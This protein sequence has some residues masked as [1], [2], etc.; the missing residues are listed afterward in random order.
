MTTNQIPLPEGDDEILTQAQAHRLMR[1]T[2]STFRGFLERGEIPVADELGVKGAARV[3]RSDVL[4]LMEKR[5]IKL[6][7]AVA[8]VPAQA[9]GDEQC[10]GCL[11]VREQMRRMRE[12]MDRMERVMNAALRAAVRTS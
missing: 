11:A 7:E 3:R 8:P 1:V 9:P 10:Q 12:D 4:R 5:G 6:T 2:R